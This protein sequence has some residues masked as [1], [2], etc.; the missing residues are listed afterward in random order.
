MIGGSC[1]WRS[2]GPRSCLPAAVFGEWRS[3]EIRHFMP[4]QFMRRTECAPTANVD[5]AARTINQFPKVPF[6]GEAE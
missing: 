3:E 2:A 1:I 5:L 4:F 6:Q